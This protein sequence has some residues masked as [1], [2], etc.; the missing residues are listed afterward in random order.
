MIVTL[1]GAS[2]PDLNQYDEAYRLGYNIG[3][4]NN[5]LKNGGYGGTMEASAK[6]CMAAGGEVI[7]VGVIGHKIDALGH[8]NAF[9]TSF[10]TKENVT[11]RIEE[12]LNTDLIIVLPGRLGTLEELFVAWIK[13]IEGQATSIFLVGSQ[14]KKLIEF[15][16]EN[17]FI[18]LDNLKY[19]NLIASVEDIQFGK[20]GQIFLRE[21]QAFSEA[22]KVINLKDYVY[23]C[24]EEEKFA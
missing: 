15:L 24:K 23:K 3:Q 13:S 4:S 1:F 21:F 16:V 9:N 14:F 8:P 6:G 2:A 19:I 17:M 5:I 7:G 11:Q 22:G 10:I 18:K 20:D 12:M